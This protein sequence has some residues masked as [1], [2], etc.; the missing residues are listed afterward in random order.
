MCQGSQS[1][2]R[3]RNHDERLELIVQFK[4]RDYNRSSRRSIIAIGESPVLARS[5]RAAITRLSVMARAIQWV[6]RPG[7]PDIYAVQGRHKAE[8]FNRKE[9]FG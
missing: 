3:Y 2:V 5:E 1:R 7:D 8:K 9:V 4:V 6:V